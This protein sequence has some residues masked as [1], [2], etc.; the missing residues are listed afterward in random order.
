MS[1]VLVIRKTDKTIHQVPLANK[2]TLMA[3]NNRLPDAEKWG[4]EEMEEEEA[5]KLPFIDEAYVTAAEAQD[6]AKELAATV[7]QKDAKI[8]ELEAKLAALNAGSN[9]T[10]L[11]L[12]KSMNVEPAVE[13][14]N[15]ATTAEEV[16]A[17]VAGDTR[18]TI[19]KAVEAKLTALNAGS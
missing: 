4:I 6:K 17:M 13:K 18:A 5:K 7:E 11:V 2:A 15:A 10:D 12:T 1:K 9:S 19:V 8:L 14:I 3:Y 16:N